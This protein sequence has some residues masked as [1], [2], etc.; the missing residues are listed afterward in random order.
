MP[1]WLESPKQSIS[2]RRV[3]HDLT[4]RLALVHQFSEGSL[5]HC[6][7]T[8]FD[9]LQATR[10]WLFISK[11]IDG[12]REKIRVCLQHDE[13]TQNNPALAVS[14]FAEIFMF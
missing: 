1:E 4:F 8:A 12:T 2:I 7:L 14:V 6:T 10:C 9:D 11:T 13:I 5:L 3:T